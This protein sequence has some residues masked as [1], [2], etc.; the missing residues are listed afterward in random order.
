[1]ARRKNK[2]ADNRKLGRLPSIMNSEIFLIGQISERA[3]STPLWRT[4]QTERQEGKQNI[5]KT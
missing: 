2:G 1:M 4:G 3:P 5:A